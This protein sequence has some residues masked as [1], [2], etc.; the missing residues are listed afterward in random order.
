MV[1]EVYLRAPAAFC[2]AENYILQPCAY[3]SGRHSP[4]AFPLLKYQK[5]F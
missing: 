4:T 5:V 3:K 1:N 2:V